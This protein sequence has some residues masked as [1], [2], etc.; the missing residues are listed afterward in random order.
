MAMFR[1][2]GEASG[3]SN[4]ENIKMSTLAEQ[5]ALVGLTYLGFREEIQTSNGVADAVEVDLEVLTGPNV[6][7]VE[8][9]RLV[10]NAGIKNALEGADEGDLIVGKIENRTT[11]NGR[12]AVCLVDASED[13]YDRARAYYDA[14]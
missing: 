7:K 13:E 12:V 8:K 4:T 1:T 2:V 9:N 5:G 6:G 11:K 10:F 14:K 3:R